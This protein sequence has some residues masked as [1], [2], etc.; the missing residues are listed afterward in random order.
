MSGPSDG[1]DLFAPH[2]GYHEQVVFFGTVKDSDQAV[3][4]CLEPGLQYG[5]RICTAGQPPE[6]SFSVDH[7][8]VHGGFDVERVGAL[9]WT[10]LSV[11]HECTTYTVWVSLPDTDLPT[12]YMLIRGERC[13]RLDFDP[14]SIISGLPFD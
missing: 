3:C 12:G 2:C 4:I 13:V 10:S 6:V 7:S 8:A 5:F 14:A 1:T 11:S 9:E